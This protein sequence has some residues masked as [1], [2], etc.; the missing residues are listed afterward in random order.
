MRKTAEFLGLPAGLP[1][2][3]GSSGGDSDVGVLNP[4][5]GFFRGCGRLCVKLTRK[6][7]TCLLSRAR[8]AARYGGTQG[9]LGSSACFS[10]TVTKVVLGLEAHQTE[11]QGVI[12]CPECSQGGPS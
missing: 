7:S 1:S 10:R 4:K 11:G 5:T 12:P 8:A 6:S 2:S 3:S 9:P